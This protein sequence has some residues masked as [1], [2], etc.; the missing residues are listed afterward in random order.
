MFDITKMEG[1]PEDLAKTAKFP[2]LWPEFKRLMAKREAI[3]AQSQPL[4]DE[5]KPIIEKIAA[6]H[7]QDMDIVARIEAIQQPLYDE[8]IDAQLS[9]LSAAFN[10][11]RLSDE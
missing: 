3:M 11:T 7:K 5:R 6:L 1:T 2:V 10:G 8:N 9:A 4:E